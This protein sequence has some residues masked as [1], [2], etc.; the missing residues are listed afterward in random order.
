MRGPSKADKEKWQKWADQETKRVERQ[1]T[2]FAMLPDCHATDRLKQAM[3]DRAWA[4]LD[5]GLEGTAACDAL[6][7]FL[8]SN[9]ADQLLKEYFGDDE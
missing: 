4:L 8:P 6:L 3:L 2:L 9:D 5:G 1:R 7:E